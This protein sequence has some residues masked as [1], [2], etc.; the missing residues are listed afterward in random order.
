MDGRMNEWY[1]R[2]DEQMDEQM[3]EWEC[4]KDVMCVPVDLSPVLNEWSRTYKYA[5]YPQNGLLGPAPRLAREWK[6]WMNEWRMKNE[7]M[8]YEEWWWMS[9]T[10]MKMNEWSRTK[11]WMICMEWIS[12]HWPGRLSI[13]WPK[14]SPSTGEEWECSAWNFHLFGLGHEWYNIIHHSCPHHRL[15]WTGL[16]PHR[17]E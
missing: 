11:K 15:A 10:W 4:V 17:K 7:W 6:W 14:A 13:A 1:E 12:N 9:S 16:D 5:D 2:M 8:M 3:N